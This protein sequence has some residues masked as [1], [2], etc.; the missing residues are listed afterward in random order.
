MGLSTPAMGST[1]QRSSP[2]F[3]T[4][5]KSGGARME[6][7]V[8]IAYSMTTD[9][10]PEYGLSTLSLGREDQT[11]DQPVQPQGFRKD[12]Y[13]HHADEQLRLLS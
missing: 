13:E 6:Q 9:M 1:R 5:S 7:A 10:Q 4:Q 8:G 11:N 3:E 2:L 12:Q